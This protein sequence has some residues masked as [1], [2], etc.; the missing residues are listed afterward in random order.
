MIKLR[1]YIG[2]QINKCMIMHIKYIASISGLQFNEYNKQLD[3]FKTSI[4][5]IKFIDNNGKATDNK[6]NVLK[7]QVRSQHDS[8]VRL[9]ETFLRAR[10]AHKYNRNDNDEI[11][12]K[13]F[14][15][16]QYITEYIDD[17]KE[18]NTNG[19]AWLDQIVDDVIKLYAVFVFKTNPIGAK[20]NIYIEKHYG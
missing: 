5:E 4:A 9:K 2:K 20:R 17:D 19:D 15:N 18:D 12:S 11:E 3:A 8:I 13:M 16:E 14:E 7:H 1:Y 10:N 6:L